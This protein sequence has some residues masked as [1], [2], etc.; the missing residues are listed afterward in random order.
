MQAL[1]PTTHDK[2]TQHAQRARDHKERSQSR[3]DR[4]HE[5][6]SCGP[7]DQHG[8]RIGNDRHNGTRYT[9]NIGSHYARDLTRCAP[10]RKAPDA[11][12]RTNGT[13]PKRILQTGLSGLREPPRYHRQKHLHQESRRKQG[14]CWQK[15]VYVM[16]HRSI[17]RPLHKQCVAHGYE[18]RSTSRDAQRPN[19]PQVRTASVKDP[20]KFSHLSPTLLATRPSTERHF[21]RARLKGQRLNHIR[22]YSSQP[23]LRGSKCFS[24]RQNS[25]RRPNTASSGTSSTK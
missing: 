14:K 7:S 12:D 17:N 20:T 22:A 24:P 25:S 1:E 11:N 4:K 19:T 9:G 15:R 8:C 10:A 2:R 6:K 18:R 13:R 21:L 16:R 23:Q 3:C 5:H